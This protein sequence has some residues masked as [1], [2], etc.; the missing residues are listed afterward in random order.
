MTNE[1]KFYRSVV[2]IEILSEEPY[3]SVD[4]AQIHYD[5]T[6]GPCSGQIDIVPQ[7]E[8]KTG[9]EMAQLLLEQGTDPEFFQ[10]TSEG[11]DIE[12]NECHWLISNK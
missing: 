1:R 8:V 12:G 5:I 3:S 10:L 2:T 7:N 9:K 4:L 11:V 6:E